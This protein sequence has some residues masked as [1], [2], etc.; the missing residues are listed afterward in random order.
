M[1]DSTL[2]EYVVNLPPRQ[3]VCCRKTSKRTGV[4]PVWL[5][6]IAAASVVKAHGEGAISRAESKPAP[7]PKPKAIRPKAAPKPAPV[8]AEAEG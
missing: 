8:N 2:A 5:T 3:V 4:G 1:P 7:R 6:S